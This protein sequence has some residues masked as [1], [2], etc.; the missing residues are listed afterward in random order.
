MLVRI[1]IFNGHLLVTFC[2]SLV[3]GE[4]SGKYIMFYRQTPIV[5]VVFFVMIFCGHLF[6]GILI[7]AVVLNICLTYVFFY[8]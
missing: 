5:D 2:R 8:G 1:V 4:G 3:S 6:V 7:N